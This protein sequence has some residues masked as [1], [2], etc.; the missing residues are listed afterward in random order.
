MENSPIP[1]HLA[2]CNSKMVLTT[3]FTNVNIRT[4]KSGI[5]V[6]SPFHLRQSRTD[7]CHQIVVK[8]S[9]FPNWE[10]GKGFGLVGVGPM[11]ECKAWYRGWHPSASHLQGT[12]ALPCGWLTDHL[13]LCMGVGRARDST[14]RSLGMCFISTVLPAPDKN[15]PNKQK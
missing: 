7:K 11:M 13:E 3:E 10:P 8:A 6:V 4:S 9:I 1:P 14:L 5:S 15:K 12:D 2:L